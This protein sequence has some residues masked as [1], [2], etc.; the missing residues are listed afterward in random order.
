MRLEGYGIHAEL[1]DGWEGRI[2]RLF[3]GWPTLHVANFPLP[4]KDGEFGSVALSTMDSSGAF[5]ALTEYAPGLAG[6]GLFGSPV[7]TRSLVAGDFDSRVMVRMRPGRFGVQRFFT[8]GTRPFCLH[9]VV[10]SLP[11]VSQ[12]AAV[13][14]SILAGL[15][16]DPD[17]GFPGP[18]G[19]PEADQG[20]ARR[21]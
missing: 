19:G 21:M 12:L 5:L 17:S 6:R 20:S 13:A 3:G 16:I 1:P 4:P 9:V 7:I 14:S 11:G 18:E 8:V 2:F 10:G 15:R